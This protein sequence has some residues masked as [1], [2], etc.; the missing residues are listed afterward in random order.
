V[1]TGVK[2]ELGSDKGRTEGWVEGFPV[3]EFWSP[4]LCM[5]NA[6]VLGFGSWVLHASFSQPVTCGFSEGN[7][8]NRKN[9]QNS[10]ILGHTFV[11]FD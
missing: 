7:I 4:L 6:A 3:A 11:P 2:A 8:C 10:P 5:S 1:A 9:S